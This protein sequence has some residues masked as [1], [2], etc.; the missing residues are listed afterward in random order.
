[1]NSLKYYTLKRRLLR[2]P[3]AGVLCNNVEKASGRRGK[4]WRSPGGGKR[5]I[6]WLGLDGAERENAPNSA[7]HPTSIRINRLISL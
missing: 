6:W 3:L 7:P 1:M 5:Q 4:V 2:R